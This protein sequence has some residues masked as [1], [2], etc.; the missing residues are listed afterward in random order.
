MDNKNVL[1]NIMNCGL[2]EFL[3]LDIEGH[4]IVHTMRVQI[5]LRMSVHYALFE[6]SDFKQLGRDKMR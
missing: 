5:R 2:M 6:I 1:K 4:S 3:I